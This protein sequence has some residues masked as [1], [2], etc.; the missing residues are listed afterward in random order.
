MSFST[1]LFVFKFLPIVLLLYFLVPIKLKNPL[2]LIASLFFYAWGEPIYVFLLLFMI[3][4]NYLFGLWIEQ[5]KNKF[6][7]LCLSI[8]LNIFILFYFKYYSFVLDTLFS[9][10]PFKLEYKMFDMPLGV[11]F[12]IFSCLAYLFDIYYKKTKAEHNIF[13]FALF[14][15]FFPKLV[16]GPITTYSQFKPQIRNHPIR[17]NLLNTGARRFIIGLAQKVILANTF[18]SLYSSLNASDGLSAWLLMIAYTL[19]IYFDF[20]GYTNMAIGLGNIFGFTLPENF[21]YPYLSLS[22]SDFWRR[23]HITLG[24]FFRDYVYIP[25]GGN[26]VPFKRHIINLLIVWMLTGLWHGANWTF[27]FWGLYYGVILILEKYLLKDIKRILPS[28]INWLITIFLI[29]IGWVFFSSPSIGDAFNTII[30]L[31]SFSTSS[32]SLFYLKTYSIYLIIGIIGC[33]PL[34]KNIGINLNKKF[35]QYY[36]LINNASGAM[37]LIISI[38]Y[39]ISSTY[40][41]F[42][43]FSF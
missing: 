32:A 16:M 23:W 13:N 3:L 22:V 9:I 19:D 29:M 20:V 14:V 36:Y 18:A 38:A 4:L 11:S 35:N 34:L 6:E 17:T 24:S 30:H 10:L 8:G 41:S 1:L 2:L 43:Y 5:T 39:M 27:I 28:F 15:S 7:A 42:L 37:L 26:R 31:F 33:T 21:N 40:Q 12:F 25:L